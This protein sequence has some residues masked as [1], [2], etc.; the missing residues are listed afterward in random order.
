VV[1]GLERRFQN[2]TE[3]LK[4][5]PVITGAV[6][7][8]SR[9][10]SSKPAEDAFHRFAC[11]KPQAASKSCTG[12]DFVSQIARYGRRGFDLPIRVSLNVPPAA[13]VETN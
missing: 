7:T 10:N 9:I 4:G 2:P 6:D 8:R 11:W 1:Q 5:M 13:W 3:L 12:Q